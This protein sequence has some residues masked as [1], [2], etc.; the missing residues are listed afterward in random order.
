LKPG[1][2]ILLPMNKMWQDVDRRYKKSSLKVE[3][4]Q[5]APHIQYQ[6]SQAMT[7]TLAAKKGI[8]L[9]MFSESAND[10]E[11]EKY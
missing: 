9:K 3:Q 8:D 11:F 6:K 1:T 4:K 10:S 7:S 2:N 5:K